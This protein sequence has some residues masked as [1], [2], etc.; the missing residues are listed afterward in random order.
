MMA[1]TRMAA[2]DESY[3]LDTLLISVINGFDVAMFFLNRRSGS[4][5]TSLLKL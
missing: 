4:P 5:L 2:C 1:Q 3:F